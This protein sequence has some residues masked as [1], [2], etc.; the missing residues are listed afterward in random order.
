MTISLQ[1]MISSTLNFSRKII[2]EENSYF[3]Y[4]SAKKGAALY[5]DNEY[6]TFAT[7]VTITDSHFYKNKAY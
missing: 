3:R 6:K 4:L 7:T 5:I 1:H 2:I